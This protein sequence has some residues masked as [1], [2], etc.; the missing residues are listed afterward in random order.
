MYYCKVHSHHPK[1]QNMFVHHLKKKETRWK[2]LN[3]RDK[4]MELQEC[5]DFKWV[6]S[7]QEVP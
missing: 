6:V 5:P 1:A 2:M 3:I 4:K 7:F